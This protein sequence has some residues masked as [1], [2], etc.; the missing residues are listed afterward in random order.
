M[1]VDPQGT[2]QKSQLPGS[3]T[4]LEKLPDMAVCLAMVIITPLPQ[5]ENPSSC[6]SSNVSGKVDPG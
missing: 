3:L 4:L 6:S 5:S 1:T 2:A